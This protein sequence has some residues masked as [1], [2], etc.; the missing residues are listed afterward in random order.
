MR[1]LR[2]RR[3]VLVAD[4]DCSAVDLY[5][6]AFYGKGRLKM[7][8]HTIIGHPNN[9]VVGCFD[10]PGSGRSPACRI[11]GPGTLRGGAFGILAGGKLRLS[12]ITIEDAHRT[13]VEVTGPAVIKGSLIRGNGSDPQG[14]AGAGVMGGAAVRIVDSVVADN[15]NTGVGSEG[16]IRLVRTSASGNGE[17]ALCAP[18]HVCA[19]LAALVA[20]RVKAGSSCGTSKSFLDG[21]TFGVCTND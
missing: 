12:D 15:H 14:S 6:I 21:T 16:S 19:D 2:H 9:P 4:L 18:D 7:N 11:Q 5:A 20:P 8:G 10:L 17:G 3:R 1:Q 13:G